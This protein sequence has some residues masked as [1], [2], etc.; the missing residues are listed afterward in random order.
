MRT[1]ASKRSRKSS[2]YLERHVLP[3]F[4]GRAN[5]ALSP[6]IPLLRSVSSSSKAARTDRQHHGS[7]VREIILYWAGKSGRRSWT[8]LKGAPANPGRFKD[9]LIADTGH[10]TFIPEA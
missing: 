4:K 5:K 2:G 8:Q 1:G 7:G 6:S 3:Y 9:M 10:S